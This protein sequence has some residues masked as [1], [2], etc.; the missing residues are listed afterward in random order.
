MG[1]AG[2]GLPRAAA[3]AAVVVACALV[4]FMLFDGATPGYT[5][6][7][8]FLNGSQLVKGN[9]RRHRRREGRPREGASRSRRT[10]RPRS[11][12]R[13]TTATRRCATARAR[14]IRASGL[15][16]VS[17][18]YVQLMLPSEEEAG[19][20][21]PGRRGR[22][23]PT[24]PRRR[25][26]STSSS[27]SSTARPGRRCRRFYKG[28]SRQYAGRG[29]EANRGLPY[30]NPQLAASA[31]ACSRSCATTRRCSSASWSTRR[32]SSRRWR[33]GATTSRR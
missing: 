14:S 11:S 12:S 24:T 9:H 26:T 8:R 13:S 29:E 5:V 18:R 3:I 2:K 28:G 23:T 19:E 10:A 30:L 32:A 22:S 6:K 25:S 31:R 1:P 15:S 20:R 17:G 16:S 21:H 27:T 33:T 7:A 4:A